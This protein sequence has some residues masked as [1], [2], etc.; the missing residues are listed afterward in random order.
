MIA[1]PSR[2]RKT[3]AWYEWFSTINLVSVY[4]FVDYDMAVRNAQKSM[5]IPFKSTDLYTWCCF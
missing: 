3:E 2:Y 4:N 1:V 5:L